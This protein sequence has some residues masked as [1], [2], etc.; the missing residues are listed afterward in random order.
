[1]R[2]QRHLQAQS[3]LALMYLFFMLS[4]YV[5]VRNKNTKT[6]TNKGHCVLSRVLSD[7]RSRHDISAVSHRAQHD[8]ECPDES[9]SIR[10]TN[11]NVLMF[12]FVL[13]FLSIEFLS[14]FE[15][16]RCRNG[17]VE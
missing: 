1:M 17:C 3:P 10:L 13:F 5:V 9:H 7:H 4:F 15:G 11:G 16:A 12:F 2:M 6:Q 14:R 8:N